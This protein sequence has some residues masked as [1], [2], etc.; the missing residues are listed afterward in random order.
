M[1]IQPPYTSL[2]AISILLISS[3]QSSLALELKPCRSSSNIGLGTK[4]TMVKGGAKIQHVSQVSVNS[5]LTEDIINALSTAK[6]DASIEI[7]RFMGSTCTSEGCRSIEK[8]SDY[9]DPGEYLRAFVPIKQCYNPKKFVKVMVE[10]S[11]NT[12]KA[13]KTSDN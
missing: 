13:A 9:K 11:P 4:V 1:T 3:S 2:L 7:L 12:M 5:D 6:A 8:I 10:L